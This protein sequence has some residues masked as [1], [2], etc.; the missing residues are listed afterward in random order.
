MELLTAG[1][2]DEEI[3]QRVK[4]GSLMPVFR[5]VYRV[6]HMA[7]STEATYIAAV[8]AAG[9]GAVLSGAAAAHLLGIVRG[10]APPAEVTAPKER[11]IKGVKTRRIALHKTERTTWNRIPITTPART[12]VDLAA[13]L[14]EPILSRAVHEAQVRHRVT[15]AD[16]EAVLGRNRNTGGARKLRRISHGEAPTV[17]SQMEQTFLQLLKRER[18]PLPQT[19][20]RID[21]RYVDCRWPA[22]RLTVEL[23]SYGYH[24]SR[25]AWERDRRREREAYARGDQIRRYTYRDVCEDPRQ[26]L[27]ELR[28]LLSPRPS[29]ASR[30]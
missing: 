14:S 20:R 19:N 8:K 1:V 6:G 24:N 18:L 25:H 30:T 28:P 5:G 15:P 7:P 17:L 21:G 3:R 22:H 10:T 11:S 12:L 9:E 13:S 26:I 4:R 29:G 16:I 2:T 27:A 23:D